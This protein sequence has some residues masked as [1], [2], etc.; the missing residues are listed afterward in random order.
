MNV[1]G[2]PFDAISREAFILKFGEFVKPL[3][4]FTANTA[5]LVNPAN[6]SVTPVDTTVIGVDW[7]V[8]GNKFRQ[9]PRRR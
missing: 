2:N 3:D 8:N 6:L 5:T 4:G 7:F 1:L 9:T